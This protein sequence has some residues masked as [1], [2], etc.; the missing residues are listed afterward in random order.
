[1]TTT[2]TARHGNKENCDSCQLCSLH[3]SSRAALKTYQP[4]AAACNHVFYTTIT[5]LPAWLACLTLQLLVTCASHACSGLYDLEGWKHRDSMS[6]LYIATGG[7]TLHSV[8]TLH[9]SPH[10]ARHGTVCEVEWFE[11]EQVDRGSVDDHVACGRQRQVPGTHW[12]HVQRQHHEWD[13]EVPAA[14]EHATLLSYTMHIFTEMTPLSLQMDAAWP[15]LAPHLNSSRA[16]GTRTTAVQAA[17][18]QRHS[19]LCRC[20]K[21]RGVQ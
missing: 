7:S 1:M 15:H 16:A 19:L 5:S 9:P 20:C 13:Q 3:V 10:E 12:L 14:S 17:N 2:S 18:A 21:N 6:D 4:N 11:E 8:S